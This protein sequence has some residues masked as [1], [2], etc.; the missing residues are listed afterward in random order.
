MDWDPTGTFFD[1]AAS[2]GGGFDAFGGTARCAT[3]SPGS[4][5]TATRTQR[6]PSS[7]NVT[8][9]DS[10]FTVVDTGGVAYTGGHNKSLNHAVSQRRG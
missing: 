5:A 1:I 9:F 6:F 3:P 10:L 8:G 2:G 4:G 7:C